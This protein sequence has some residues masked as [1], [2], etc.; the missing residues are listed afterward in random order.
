MPQ[1]NNVSFDQN[2][3]YESTIL[4]LPSPKMRAK[5]TKIGRL[6]SKKM[7]AINKHQMVQSI[8]NV[9]LINVIA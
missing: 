6:I 4:F 9:F 2:L 3:R 8:S 5:S 7:P 1:K